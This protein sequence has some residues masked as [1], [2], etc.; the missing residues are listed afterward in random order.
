M[1]NRFLTYILSFVAATTLLSCYEDKGTY[2]YRN[3]NQIEIDFNIS[4]PS[5]ST[6]IGSTVEINPTIKCS[7]VSKKESD[8][9]YIWTVNQ[10]TRDD[11]NKPTF[12]W[13]VD[14][15]FE[16]TYITLEVKDKE[17]DVSFF[18][19]IFVQTKGT[20]NLGDAWMILS[21][22]NGESIVSA[23][24][25]TKDYFSDDWLYIYIETA[26][27][28]QDIYK[29]ENGVAV[30]TGP[31][32][33]VEHYNRSNNSVGS[34]LALQN[35]EPID[36]DGETMLKDIDL[37]I[38]FDGEVLPEKI[39][40]ACYKV[41][42]D[43]LVGESG[44]LYSRLRTDNLVF[45]SGKFLPTPIKFNDEILEQCEIVQS[46]TNRWGTS[47]TIIH[48]KKNK[49]MFNIIDSRGSLFPYVDMQN[50][51]EGFI[52]LNDL[53]SCEVLHVGYYRSSN[54]FEGHHCMVF[55]KGNEYYF[56]KFGTTF[57]G[58]VCYP[59]SCSVGKING[60]PGDP[61]SICI[62]PFQMFQPYIFLAVGSKLYVCD[63]SN[64]EMPVFLYH[65]F[66]ADIASMAV[67]YYGGYHGMVGLKNG[68]F[69]IINIAEAKN[70][71]PDNRILYSS[72]EGLDLG[73]IKHV[74]RKSQSMP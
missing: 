15:K 3:V 9:E 69:A 65:E 43:V 1:K 16:G 53:S 45:N 14:E 22:K 37:K 54:Y 39:V 71:A 67:G 17:T 68:K 35:S 36:I 5:I 51:P 8:L 48:D 57:S 56:Q 46:P 24:K 49:R 62:E 25:I 2:D 72:P 52:P 33:L 63:S 40:D 20:Y 31:I 13:V 11:W 18:Q 44:R 30:G 6:N 55:K 38:A 50:T 61:T 60:L 73:V 7:D 64:P 12:E 66:D 27:V 59:S 19:N 26:E 47:A 70:N 4:T 28:L 34:L 21:E 42:T 23:L 41:N 32:K 74:S 58:D 29:K 10:K